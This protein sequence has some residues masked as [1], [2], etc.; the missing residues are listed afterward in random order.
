MTIGRLGISSLDISEGIPERTCR[1]VV[2]LTIS[3]PFLLL[4]RYYIYSS[5]RNGVLYVLAWVALVACLRG[6][7]T[8]VGG[9][10]GVLAC[11]V[12]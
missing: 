2:I 5:L 1:V 3:N 4:K 11:V 12:C 7:H 8:N 10:D 9:V 6:W